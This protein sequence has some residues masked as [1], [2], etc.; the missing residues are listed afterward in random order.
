MN[1]EDIRN[2]EIM[3]RK[4]VAARSY[5]PDALSDLSRYARDSGS[6]LAGRSETLPA[7]PTEAVSAL[8][9]AIEHIDTDAAERVFQLISWYQVQR[10]RTAGDVRDQQDFV[11]HAY[12]IVLLQAYVSSLFGYARN[13]VQTKKYTKPTQNE[14]NTAKSNVFDLMNQ[15]LDPENFHSLDEIISRRHPNDT[16]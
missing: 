11:E 10:A 2:K 8:K 15:A 16:T 7:P 3:S 5:M 1:Q 9:Q 4:A 12:D 14:M 13:E 6:H